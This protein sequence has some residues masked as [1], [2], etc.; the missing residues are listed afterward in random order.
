MRLKYVV[1]DDPIYR[2]LVSENLLSEMY[3]RL[4][5]CVL[6]NLGSSPAPKP[7]SVLP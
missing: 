4:A 7:L 1:V 5:N 3:F 6:F 2:G